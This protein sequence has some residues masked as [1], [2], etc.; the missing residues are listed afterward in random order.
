MPHCDVTEPIVT[1]Q[2]PI[3]MLQS[4]IVTSQSRHDGITMLHCDVTGPDYEITTLNCDVT[5]PIVKSQSSI[6][7][8]R[9]PMMESQCPT[10]TSQTA[11]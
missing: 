3:V 7:T 5:E 6:V 9:S 1:S 8:S 2:S 10:V 4:P 11:L